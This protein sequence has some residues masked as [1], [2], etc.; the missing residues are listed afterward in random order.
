VDWTRL[1]NKREQEINLGM[2]PAASE[3]SEAAEKR[4]VAGEAQHLTATTF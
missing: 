1:R 2:K 3:A 4:R